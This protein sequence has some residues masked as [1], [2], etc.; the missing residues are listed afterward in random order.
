MLEAR[1][2]IKRLLIVSKYLDELIEV[3][4]IVDFYMG[5]ARKKTEEDM[6]KYQ[7]NLAMD[8]L[9][10]TIGVEPNRVKLDTDD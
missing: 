6:V 3:M 5:E 7:A 8:L 2:Q 9:T 1:T 10:Q 4:L